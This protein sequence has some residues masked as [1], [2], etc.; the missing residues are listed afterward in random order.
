MTSQIH[1]NY[2]S[3][4]LVSHYHM[5]QL[6]SLCFMR[7][8]HMSDIKQ[9]EKGGKL[10]KTESRTVIPL[11][12]YAKQPEQHVKRRYLEKISVIGIDRATLADLPLDPER[13]P[14]IESTDLLCYLV[15]DT[16]YYTAQQ[17]K[18]FK[19][20]EAYNQMVSGFITSVQGKIICDKFVVL[21]KVRHSQRMTECRCLVCVITTKEGSILSAHCLG[22]KAGLGETCSHIA[23]ILFYIGAWTRIHGKLACT[24]VKCTWLLPTYVNEVPYATEENINFRSAAKF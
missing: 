6:S 3:A 22:C 7:E 20:L 24:Q 16:S 11:G 8:F 1:S 15:I 19:S 9:E 5:K 18:A 14:L 17:F 21:G 2:L 23:S 10:Q 13:L 12:K 4:V